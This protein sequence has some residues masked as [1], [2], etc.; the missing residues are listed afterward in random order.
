MGAPRHTAKTVLVLGI[1][2][3]HSGRGISGSEI[4]KLTGLWSGTAYPIL[5][6]IADAGWVTAAWEEG[7]P[8]ELGR[9]LKRVYRITGAGQ[10]QLREHRKR[11]TETLSGMAWAN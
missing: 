6:R 5:L 4:M 1:I 10:A 3:E 9:P 2:A 11:S 8:S 7:D